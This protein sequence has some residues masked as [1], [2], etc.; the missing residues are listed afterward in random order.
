MKISVEQTHK[1]NIVDPFF[2]PVKIIK[3]IKKNTKWKG[4]EKGRTKK[5]VVAPPETRNKE[6]NP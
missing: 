2:Y 6:L 5:Y 1:N 4:R 3:Y